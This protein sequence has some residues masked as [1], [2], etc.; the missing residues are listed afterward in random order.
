MKKRGAGA[1]T[2]ARPKKQKKKMKVVAFPTDWASLPVG[3][4]EVRK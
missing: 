2:K 4:Q 3:A 1:E